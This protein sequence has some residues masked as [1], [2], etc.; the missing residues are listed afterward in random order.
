MKLKHPLKHVMIAKNVLA[1]LGHEAIEEIE[2]ELYNDD[3]VLCVNAR[4]LDGSSSQSYTWYIPMGKDYEIEL[5]D[6]LVVEQVVGIGLALVQAT[7]NPYFKTKEMHE[8]DV[9]PYCK[10]IRNLGK[11]TY[12]Y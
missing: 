6:T 10:V 3:G 12:N 5:G 11:Q 2:D 9:H 4:H 8:L 7:C 1:R